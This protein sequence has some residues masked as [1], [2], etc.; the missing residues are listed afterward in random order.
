MTVS[1]CE[2]L[3]LESVDCEGFVESV[4]IG[5]SVLVLVEDQPNEVRVPA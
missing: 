1:V 2:E 5:V 4:E 3:W